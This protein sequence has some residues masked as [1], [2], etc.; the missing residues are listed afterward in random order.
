MLYQGDVNDIDPQ[1]STGRLVNTNN[2]DTMLVNAHD[3]SGLAARVMQE[4]RI[5]EQLEQTPRQNGGNGHLLPDQSSSRLTDMLHGVSPVRGD[6]GGKFQPNCPSAV[7]S[8]LHKM[9]DPVTPLQAM[10]PRLDSSGLFGL[11]LTPKTIHDHF[12]MTNEHLDVLGKSNWDQIEELKKEMHEKSSNRHAKL[13]TTVE[14][15]VHE[16]KM[17]VDSVNEKADRTTE[18][19][20]NIHTKL[21]KLFEVVKGDVMGALAVQEKKMADMEQSV[22]DI[23]MTLQNMQRMLEQK[24]NEASVGQAHAITSPHTTLGGTSPPG[25]PGHQLQP[26][27]AGYYGNMTE[28][29]REGQPLMPHMQDH[30]SSSMAQD[31][32]SDARA[33]YGSSLEQ[34]WGPRAS[35]QGRS[36]KEERPYPGTNPYQFANSVANG[37]GQFSNGYSGGYSAYGQQ[38]ESHYAFHPGAAK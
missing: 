28:S 3:N 12:Y 5:G 26:S 17:Q 32:Q 27:L 37:A 13:V 18:Q 22:R 15:H 11:A 1:S 19:S 7:P 24:H 8:P 38:G 23:H 14:K 31:A 34:R 20:H 33:G 9:T 16:I 29:G 35:F 4:L 2:Q 30:R 10:P 36:S 25:P 21:E 6:F